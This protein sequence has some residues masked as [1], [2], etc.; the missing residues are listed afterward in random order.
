MKKTFFITDVL[1]LSKGNVPKWDDL[2]VFKYIDGI[3]GDI[4]VAE[5]IKMMICTKPLDLCHRACNYFNGQYDY[6]L[7][8]NG[9]IN[10]AFEKIAEKKS[11]SEVNVEIKKIDKIQSTIKDIEVAEVAE[12]VTNVESVT[13]NVTEAKCVL[14]TD[15]IQENVFDDKIEYDD[16][17]DD[18]DDV[19]P[20]KKKTTSKKTVQEYHVPKFEQEKLTYVEA[21]TK[22]VTVDGLVKELDYY[23]RIKYLA[24]KADMEKIYAKVFSELQTK[25]FSIPVKIESRVHKEASKAVRIEIIRKA[26]H[27][28]LNSVAEN[29]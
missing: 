21:L 24:P 29:V 14:I 11:M 8:D 23:E 5:T 6:L 25:L 26:I 4:D 10:E 28:A 9:L 20:V 1:K 22:K 18:I 3:S 13:D 19:Q 2:G 15:N 7:K 12:V 27:S 17:D 16:I